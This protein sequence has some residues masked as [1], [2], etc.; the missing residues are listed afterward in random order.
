MTAP[1]SKIFSDRGSTLPLIAGLFGLAAMLIY[2]SLSAA[3]VFIELGRLRTLADAT[4]LYAS[5]SFSLDE[6]RL[7]GNVPRQQLTSENVLK[8]S[9]NFLARR[10]RVP[11]LAIK[12]AW[13]PD[14]Q[15]ARVTLTTPWRPPLLPSLLKFD[16]SVTS[17]ARTLFW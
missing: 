4:A 9:A 5:E 11:E 15:S 8:S 7:T 3:S 1:N 12:R 14:G 13:S 10:Q 2:F 16:V 17:T 6:V